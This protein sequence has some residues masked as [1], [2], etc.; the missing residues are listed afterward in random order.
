[1]DTSSLES[2]SRTGDGLSTVRPNI[3][4]RIT[5]DG[6]GDEINIPGVFIVLETIRRGPKRVVTL[7]E[8]GG[9]RID[10]LVSPPPPAK[11]AIAVSIGVELHW[12]DPPTGAHGRNFVWGSS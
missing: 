4:D 5:A 3:R 7:Q 12:Y 10:V 2:S 11:H 1:M 8:I 6:P 9:E